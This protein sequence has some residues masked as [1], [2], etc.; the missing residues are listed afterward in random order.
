M[1][2][3]RLIAVVLAILLTCSAAWAADA[4]PPTQAVADFFNSSL[5]VT[6]VSV[7]TSS[8]SLGTPLAGRRRVMIQNIKSSNTASIYIESTGAAA[9]TD[10]WEIPLGTT[11][12]LDVGPGVTIYAISASGTQDIR[13]LEGK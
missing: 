8:A 9:T 10:D 12:T 3:D 1:G 7:G 13:V 2:V 6:K 4:S 11:L 5:R